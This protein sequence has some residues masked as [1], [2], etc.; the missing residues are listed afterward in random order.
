MA[1]EAVLSG[2]YDAE[3]VRLAIAEAEEAINIRERRRVWEVFA[4]AIAREQ[5]GTW[6]RSVTAIGVG[7]KADE[8]VSEWQKRFG[9]ESRRPD[10]SE[11]DE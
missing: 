3:A 8:M 5:A 2:Y 10:H 9:P 4:A 6:Q 11:R 7:A 1:G